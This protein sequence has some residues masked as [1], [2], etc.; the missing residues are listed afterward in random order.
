M[1]NFTYNAESDELEKTTHSNNNYAEYTYDASGRLTQLNNKKADN[2]GNPKECNS[3]G[4]AGNY[5]LYAGY[6]YDSETGLYYL[7]ARYYDSNTARFTSRLVLNLFQYR[8]ENQ[9]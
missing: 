9:N 2:W 4:T 6:Q 1:T 7:K 8:T 5:F 3:A